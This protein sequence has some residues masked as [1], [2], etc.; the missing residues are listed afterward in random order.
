MKSALFAFLVVLSVGC[1]G[2]SGGD[3]T[4]NMPAMPDA[5]VGDMAIVVDASVVTPTL[6]AAPARLYVPSGMPGQPAQL[7]FELIAGDAEV[8]ISNVSLAI[9][10]ARSRLLHKRTFQTGID[11][12]GMDQFSYPIVI[13]PS[14]ALPMMLE[15]TPS[16]DVDVSGM[17]TITGNFEGGELIIPIEMGSMGAQLQ[18]STTEVAFGRV[19]ENTSK[20]E[21]ITLTNTG[22][23]PLNIQNILIRSFGV[24]F[25]VELNGEDAIENVDA[26]VD[27]DG[28]GMS[29]ISP[30]S[31]ATLS[32]TY[33][34]LSEG[35]DDATITVRSDSTLNPEQV[36]ELSANQ[37]YS[38]MSV[39]PEMMRC[40][41][42]LQQ[43]TVCDT[44]VVISNCDENEPLIIDEIRMNASTDSFFIDEDS[45]PTMPHSL[46]VG[47]M[48]PIEIRYLPGV[49]RS[50]HR[51]NL[52]IHANDL[53]SP[54]R[55]IQLT[56]FTPCA[57]TEECPL[58]YE[59]IDNECIFT[60]MPGGDG[61][62]PQ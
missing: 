42:E 2:D 50:N 5:A 26:Y 58:E 32:V 25:S 38:C 60:M 57:S 53:E 10:G 43:L 54:S 23:A 61:E 56:G 51:G 3:E 44:Q 34:P 62:P 20:T 12:E 21:N 18:L 48:L 14:V 46:P 37:R 31:S 35:S 49:A 11:Y 17:L 19:A 28:D 6:E 9:S 15:V 8:E 24:D 16:G 39:S 33:A 27:P 29:G 40:E 59:C 41:G 4:Q 36:V 45:L 7:R 22:G 47:E 52:L 55:N 13:D 30:G 1:G